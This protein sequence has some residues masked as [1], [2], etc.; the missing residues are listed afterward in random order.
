MSFL[1]PPLTP[2]NGQ[3][4][5][6]LAVCRV[7]SPGENKQDI[8][9]LDDQEALLKKW[10]DENTEYPLELTVIAGSGSGENLERKEYLQLLDEISTERYDLAI[11]EDLSRIARRVHAHIVCE[12]CLD[13]ATRLIAINDR[14]DTA[15]EGWEDASMM[16]T[17]HHARSNRDT[18]DRIKRAHRNRFTV[19]GCVHQ[20]RF[21]YIKPP[22][23]KSDVDVTKDPA[24]EYYIKEWFRRLDE[25]QA[26][27][28]TIADWLNREDVPPGPNRKKKIW[29]CR[30]VASDTHNSWLKGIR[31]R[32]RQRSKRNHASGKY[33]SEKAPPEM[34]LTRNVPHLAYFEEAYY[35]RIVSAAD[36]RNAGY[37][38][39][40][41][42]GVLASARGPK[43]RTR[44]PGQCVYCGICGSMY[45]F[46]GHGQTDHLMCDGARNY[47]CWNG[48]TVDGPLAI[49]N[50]SRAILAEIETLPGYDEVFLEQIHAEAKRQ[51]ISRTERIDQLRKVQSKTD[52]E[53]K[54][55]LKAIRSGVDAQSLKDDLDRVE[56][57]KKQI[58][59]ELD[60]IAQLQG[61]QLTIPDI[62]SLKTQ[63]RE[64]FAESACNSFEFADRLRCLVP[65]IVVFPFQLIDGGPVVL[66]AKFRLQLANL[67]PDACIR[68]ALG[69]T[70]DRELQVDL[71]TPPQREEFRERVVSSR[72]QGETEQQIATSL[73]ITHTAAQRAAS[74]QRK[75]DAMGI[76]DPYLPLHSPPETGRLRRHKHHR[77]QFDP[78][79]DAGNI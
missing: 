52:R 26:S 64:I 46:G 21:G 35:D 9:S 40:D 79:P 24:A 25:E 49:Q 16:S 22:G 62:E 2:K 67:V 65:R 11:T 27:Y 28:S 61:S 51:D 13:C 41:S 74:L 53:I 29:D 15:I 75:M 44:Y 43:K 17:W 32:N 66:R 42:N 63:V 34:L 77:Y 33:V 47:K 59:Y 12:K 4:L 50:I 23:A 20:V 58:D 55:L 18:S 60:H 38:R 7:S 45:V 10:L 39:R 70:L 31:E 69:D 57:E 48:A 71:F 78:L 54:N 36:T 56:R 6:V 5:Q 14:V 1:T 73:G 19:G 8:R 37:R 72:R 76:V 3:T 30:M 68:A